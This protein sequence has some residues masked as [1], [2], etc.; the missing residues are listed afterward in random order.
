LAEL[1]EDGATGLLYEPCDLAAAITALDRTL[2]MPDEQ[3]VA[4]AER[5]SALVHARYDAARYASDVIRLLRGLQR[6]PA[7]L[8]ADLLGRPD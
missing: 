6:D 1:L 7:A 5:G 4:I 2:S 8:P 3:L